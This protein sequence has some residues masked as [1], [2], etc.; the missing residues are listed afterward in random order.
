MTVSSDIQADP[1]F[2]KVSELRVR[3]SHSKRRVLLSCYIFGSSLDPNLPDFSRAI[4]DKFG[5]WVATVK[6]AGTS[7]TSSS[8]SLPIEKRGD[9]DSSYFRIM[10]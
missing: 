10:E 7:K 4:L 8:I 3:V 1:S 2:T 5:A 9:G 6:S